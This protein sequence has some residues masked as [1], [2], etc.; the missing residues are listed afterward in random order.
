MRKTESIAGAEDGGIGLAGV[1]H[2][3]DLGQRLDQTGQRQDAGGHGFALIHAAW[4]FNRCSSGASVAAITA[5]PR[6]TSPS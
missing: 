6:Q 3:P 4:A 1:G 5:P 2:A